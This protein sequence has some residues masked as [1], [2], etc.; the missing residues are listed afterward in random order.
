MTPEDR[1]R[2][3]IQSLDQVERPTARE[4]NRMRE[5]MWSAAAAELD[6]R[7]VALDQAEIVR[8]RPDPTRHGRLALL[9]AAASILIAVGIWFAFVRD[10]EPGIVEQTDIPEQTTTIAPTTTTTTEPPTTTEATTTTAAVIDAET[11]ALLDRFETTFNAGDADAFIALFRP[12]V[13]REVIVDADRRLYDLDLVRDIYLIEADL[14][15]EITL[16]CEL[17]SGS[18]SIA[19]APTRY[20]DL[21]RILGVAGTVDNDWRFRFDEDGL[22][23]SW[24]QFRDNRIADDYE[25]EIYRP[26]DEW[27]RENHPD[28][29]PPNGLN[30]AVGGDWIVS[31]RELI[32]EMVALFAESRGVTLVEAVDE[33]DG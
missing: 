19:C 28:V 6:Q 14:N 8:L 5:Q 31:E 17:S 25:R 2:T 29:V 1:T 10:S 21:H 32:L 4:R 23:E 13:N 33:S 24:S 18:T 3:L 22:V 30:P 11:Q 27:T 16:N 12:G 15:T 26:F 7:D 20:D 9:G